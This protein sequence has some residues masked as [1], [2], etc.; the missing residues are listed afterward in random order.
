MEKTNNNFFDVLTKAK[1]L[2]LAET[3]PISDLNGNDAAA[4]IRI[5]SSL[6]FNKK[7]SKNR[8]LIEGIQNIDLTDIMHAR[9][10][11]YKIKLLA[12]LK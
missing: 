8:I 11:G 9:N 1:F 10:L 12:I 2:G 4:K 6:A 5:L 3:N 7:I